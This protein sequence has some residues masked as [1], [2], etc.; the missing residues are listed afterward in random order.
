M[1]RNEEKL[2]RWVEKLSF[3]DREKIKDCIFKLHTASEEMRIERTT[4]RKIKD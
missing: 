3:E 4:G 2:K 1:K